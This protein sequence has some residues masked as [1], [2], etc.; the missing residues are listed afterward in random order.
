MKTLIAITLIGLSA[1]AMADGMGTYSTGYRFGELTK[2]GIKGIFLKSGE[3]QMMLGNNSA[4]ITPTEESAFSNPWRFSSTSAITQKEL[5]NTMGGFVTLKYE[6]AHVKFPNVDT[7]YDIKK[8]IPIQPPITKA[9]TTED[10]NPGIKSNTTRVGRIVKA[11]TKGIGFNSYELIMQMGNAGN[12]FKHLSVTVPSIYSCAVQFL[13]AGQKVKVEYSESLVNMDLIGR[14]TPY[15]VISIT[16][17]QTL[18]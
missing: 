10:Y 5:K 18:D 3:G 2:F 6:Q 12:Q 1:T 4:V 16:P 14:E 7:D 17:V 9:C 8:V 13:K 11:S 15:D